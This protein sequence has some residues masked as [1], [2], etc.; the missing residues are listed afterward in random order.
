MT[1]YIARKVV[2]SFQK[3]ASEPVGEN[4]TSRE[5]EVLVL[6]SQ[7]YYYKEIADALNITMPTVSTHIRRIYDKLHVNSRGR[8]VAK[9]SQSVSPRPLRPPLAPG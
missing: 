9:F 8:A 7:G 1:S 6:L 3:P 5:R 4:L 2:Q